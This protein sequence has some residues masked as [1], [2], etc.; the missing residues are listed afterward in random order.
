MSPRGDPH[1]D[2]H[3]MPEFDDTRTTDIEP[4][5]DAQRLAANEALSG[6]ATAQFQCMTLGVPDQYAH[7][8]LRVAHRAADRLAQLTVLQWLPNRVDVP[9]LPARVG[10]VYSSHMD[11][12]IERASPH[13]NT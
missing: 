9:L 8:E 5:E 11:C 10:E 1:V 3:A 4:P 2:D 6:Q 12:Q 13:S 7:C